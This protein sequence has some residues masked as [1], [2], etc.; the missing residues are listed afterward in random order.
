MVLGYLVFVFLCFCFTATNPEI[1]HRVYP[2]SFVFLYRLRFL[3]FWS[4]SCLSNF[5]LGI[6]LLCVDP[7]FRSHT[8][9]F[10]LFL[11]LWITHL[12]SVVVSVGWERRE[13]DGVTQISVLV[14]LTSRFSEVARKILVDCLDRKKK[15]VEG[16]EG[17]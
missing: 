1:G 11:K 12:W 10:L 4:S 8:S 9:I 5:L 14:R 16:P 7:F 3:R 13:G 17:T 6:V 15:G 2:L